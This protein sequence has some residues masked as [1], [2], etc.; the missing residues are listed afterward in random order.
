MNNIKITNIKLLGSWPQLSQV[1]E[2]HLPELALIGRSN[3]GK[4]TLINTILDRKHFA[5]V[6]STPGKTQMAVLF[7]VDLLVK[8][9][10]LEQK[11]KVV[12][13]DLPGY[14]YAKVGKAKSA[15]FQELIISYLKKRKAL[16]AA[17]LLNDCRRAPSEDEFFIYDLFSKIG[18]RKGLVL[19]KIDKISR[20]DRTEGLKQIAESFKG[21][22]S[23]IAT[24]LKE[25][26]NKIRSEIFSLIL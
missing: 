8:I 9:E 6:S 22:D 2:F 16:R 18:I 24:G 13:V 21:F 23:L 11:R 12:L 15:D 4:S 14:G 25:D 5:K 17:Y 10:D 26:K 19:T 20:S 7:E 1:P 3:S